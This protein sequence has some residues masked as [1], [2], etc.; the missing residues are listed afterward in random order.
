MRPIDGILKAKQEEIQRRK[1]G[2]DIESVRAAAAGAP[3]ARDF[4][5]AIH[6]K[7]RI[8]LI[9]EI[10]RSSPSR[11]KI[12]ETGVEELARIYN[13]SGA[14]AISVLTDS[15]FEGE[16]GHIPVVRK[17]TEKPILRK[18][19][20]L[21]PYQ[22]FE[23]RACGADAVLL[24]ASILDETTLFGLLETCAEAGIQALVESH[25]AGD[26]ARIP[27]TA[28]IYGINNRDLNSEDLKIDM[29]T[30]PR[31]LPH[32]PEGRTVVCE[33]G[34]FERKD[35]ESI[36]ALGR[37]N[38]VLIGT[39]LLSSDDPGAKIAELMG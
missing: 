4:L 22:I 30:T 8:S 19:F 25:T 27:S 31:L 28:R 29:A 39:A 36:A 26:V 15:H 16:I 13:D 9:A 17:L 32:I 24:I 6:V 11:G 1:A 2:K 35:I 3:P 14:A 34:L 10:K 23:A 5:G 18:D 33:S 20:I 37:V 38:A 7:G 12:A 21:D